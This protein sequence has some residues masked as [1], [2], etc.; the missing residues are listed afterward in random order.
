MYI[1]DT[2]TPALQ[3]SFHPANDSLFQIIQ[4]N[5][6]DKRF[7]GAWFLTECNDSFLCYDEAQAHFKCN[8]IHQSKAEALIVFCHFLHH[9][10]STCKLHCAASHSPLTWQPHGTGN[11]T[12]QSKGG[13][14]EKKK[15][16]LDPKTLIVFLPARLDVKS[17][18]FKRKG[19]RRLWHACKVK[20][21]QDVYKQS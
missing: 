5:E 15:T 13:E 6:D 2:Q 1:R 3:N 17:G 7:P 12:L 4:F 14:K 9:H 16:Q 19:V 11:Q 8:L 20:G 18:M 21:M 10:V